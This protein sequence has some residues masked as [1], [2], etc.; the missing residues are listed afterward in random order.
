[1]EK[2]EQIIMDFPSFMNSGSGQGIMGWIGNIAGSSDGAGGDSGAGNA[3]TKI[4]KKVRGVGQTAAK[5]APSVGQGGDVEAPQYSTLDVTNAENQMSGSDFLSEKKIRSGKGA[6]ANDSG[7]AGPSTTS[8]V[9]NN[10]TSSNSQSNN[11]SNVDTDAQAEAA[12]K[13][14]DN[15]KAAEKT[16]D[17]KTAIKPTADT[18][19]TTSYSYGMQ[20]YGK[21][22]KL[23]LP[24]G[25]K[26]PSNI[27]SV[28]D[29][30]QMAGTNDDP[31]GVRKSTGMDKRIAPN[32]DGSKLSSGRAASNIINETQKVKSDCR[33]KNYYRFSKEAKIK[34]DER[35]KDSTK[36]DD[37]SLDC[38]GK[39]NAYVFKYKPEAQEMYKDKNVGVDD[40]QHVGVMAQELAANPMTNSSVNKDSNGFLEVDTKSLTMTNTAMIAELARKVSELE[41][42]LKETK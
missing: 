4:Y 30:E 5:S 24:S 42:K 15:I 37:S 33:L 28:Y 18:T 21:D 40:K 29:A 27:Q 12:K 14:I 36:D 35:L 19:A 23:V 1:M 7:T 2:G 26:A 8:S 20:P 32:D 31:F 16:I 34:S 39:I 9:N 38:F 3:A 11:N 10:T 25:D 22:N 17:V 13:I 6:Q 41:T